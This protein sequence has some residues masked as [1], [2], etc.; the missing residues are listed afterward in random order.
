[1]EIMLLELALATDI[2]LVS[3]IMRLKGAKCP[4]FDFVKKYITH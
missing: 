3:E 4:L 2:L 1:M